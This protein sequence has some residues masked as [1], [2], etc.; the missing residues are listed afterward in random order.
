MEALKIIRR[1]AYYLVFLIA[2]TLFFYEMVSLSLV[3]YKD[4]WDTF[5]FSLLFKEVYLPFFYAVISLTV[6]LLTEAFLI[7]KPKEV[8]TTIYPWTLIIFFGL[9][10]LFS[11]IIM[12]LGLIKILDEPLNKDPSFLILPLVCSIL[13]TLSEVLWGAIY[14]FKNKKKEQSKQDN[15]S[16]KDL[17]SINLHKEN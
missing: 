11:V 8:E 14:L 17:T 9:G 4:G 12:V 15:N 6:A 1:I 3:T 10:L 13:F 2:S 16:E 7:G 5:S